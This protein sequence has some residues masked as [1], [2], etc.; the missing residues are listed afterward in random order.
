MSLLDLLA[1]LGPGTFFALLLWEAWFPARPLPDAPG[2]RWLGA[3][4]LG[5]M[6]LVGTYLPLVVSEQWVN[7]Y[8]LFDLSGLD[9]LTGFCVGWLVYTLFGFLWHRAV[10]ASPL[11]WRMFHQLHHAPSRLDVASSTIFH[12]TETAAYVMLSFIT[13]V[14]VLG[15]SSVAAGYV[16]LCAAF[17]S[18][19]QHANIKTPRWLGYFI[20]RPEAHSLHH[21]ISGPQGNYSDFPLWDLLTGSFVN[22]RSFT[23]Q[24]GFA[25]NAAQVWAMLSFMDVQ[26]ETGGQP[27]SAQA[28]S[29]A[30]TPHG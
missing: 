3:L 9:P 22:P 24:V 4:G 18:F 29:P 26:K 30:A 13:T 5:I 15:L 10:H 25:K 16:G 8:R 7:E 6:M 1:L 11:L 28:T 2:F 20:Q 14:V 27:S 23:P 17:V 21:H 19:F 12:P